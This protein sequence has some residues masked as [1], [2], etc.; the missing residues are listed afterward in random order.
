MSTQD[1]TIV[2]RAPTYHLEFQGKDLNQ[3]CNDIK[4]VKRERK[5]MTIT[6]FYYKTKITR[7]SGMEIES[8]GVLG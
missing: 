3:L 6:S 5:M 2:L 1:L 8:P 7:N 4:P